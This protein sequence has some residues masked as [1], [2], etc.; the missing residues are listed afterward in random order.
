MRTRVGVAVDRVKVGSVR[1]LDPV[2]GPC[3]D[4]LPILCPRPRGPVFV[5]QGALDY[6]CG[7]CRSVVCEGIAPGDLGGIPVRC[8]CGAIGRMPGFAYGI[9]AAPQ[10]I[11][12]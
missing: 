2:E 12:K 8:R 6:V 7:Q 5:G 1:V 11:G 3:D 10:R 4:A 9:G